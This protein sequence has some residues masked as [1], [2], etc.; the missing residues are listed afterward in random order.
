[1]LVTLISLQFHFDTLF[2]ICIT[3]D[4]KQSSVTIISEAFTGFGKNHLKALKV[5][6]DAF[7]QMALQLTY[8]KLH[9]K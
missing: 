6:P 9:G 4:L 2:S 1:M 8:Y 3:L 7:I 5:H